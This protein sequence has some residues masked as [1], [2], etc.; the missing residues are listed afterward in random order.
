[1]SD[2][3]VALVGADDPGARVEFVRNA[4]GRI[5]R[6]SGPATSGDAA[7]VAY[8]YDAQGRL[9]LARSLFSAGAGTLLGYHDDG[10]LIDETISASLGTAVGWLAGASAPSDTW[11]GTLLAGQPAHLAFSVRESELASTVKTSGAQGAVI[12]AVEVAGRGRAAERRRRDD[13]RPGDERRAHRHAAAHHRSRASSCS[14]LQG[15][16]SVSVRIRLAG[17]IDRDGVVDG[18]DSAAWEAAAAQGLPSADFN[19][20]GVDDA[21]DRQV[22]YANYGWHANQAPVRDRSRGRTG[23]ARRMQTW[24]QV[25]A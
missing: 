6:V 14:T 4:Q 9:V 23:G 22:L 2:A 17:D 20:D 1:M 5:D 16:G 19:G 12:V 21:S 18:S 8:R 7:S 11:S 3:G 24:F 15:A 25:G 10:T 13:P